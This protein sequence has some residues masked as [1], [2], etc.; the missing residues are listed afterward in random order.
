[1]VL[2][3]KDPV[4]ALPYLKKVTGLKPDNQVY[5]L[6][7]AMCLIDLKQ[8]DEADKVLKRIIEIA[9]YTRQANSAK[10]FLT[11]L[12]SMSIQG[13]GLRMDVVRYCTEALGLFTKA[14][15]DKTKTIAAEIGLLG[16]NGLDLNSPEQKYSLKSLPGKFSGLQLLSYMYVAFKQLDPNLDVGVDFSKEYSAA[17][18]NFQAGHLHN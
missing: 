7:L 13:K 6:A 11:Q 8:Y 16:G 9:P 10:E 5:L 18:S 4:K 15:G 17:K 2:R 3:K 1:V 14:G 12:A